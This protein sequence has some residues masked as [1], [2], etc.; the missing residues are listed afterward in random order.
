MT[1]VVCVVGTGFS[2]STLLSF[3]LNAHPEVASVGEATGPFDQWADQRTYPCSCGETLAECAFWKRV[4]EEMRARG[5]A[6]GPNCWNLEFRIAR[7]RPLNHLLSRSLRNNAL[8]AARDRLVRAV[9]VWRNMLEA[10]ADRN[11]RL[12]ASVL[13]ITGKRVF[14]DA[15]KDPVRARELLRLTRLDLRVVHLV[16]DTPGFVS[17]FIKNTRGSMGLGI[18]YWNRMAGHVERLAALLPDD[19]F[20][21]VRYEDL[22]VATDDVLARIT[23]FAGLGPMRGPVDFRSTPHHV[24]GNR[25]RLTGSSEVRLDESWRERLSAEQVRAILRGSRRRRARLGYA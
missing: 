11:E 17:S 24:I 16:R 1:P 4:G 9:P 23:G 6:F 25:M 3:L 2:G 21:R 22:C 19:R 20:L 12:V 14:L 5:S 13:A 8:D 10:Q 15:S 18:R 7:S